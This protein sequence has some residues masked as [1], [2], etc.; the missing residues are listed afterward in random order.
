MGKIIKFSQFPAV[1]I[2]SSY[3]QKWISNYW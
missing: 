1:H 2:V 3:W